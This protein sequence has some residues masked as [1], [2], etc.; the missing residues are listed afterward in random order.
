MHTSRDFDSSR[1]CDYFQYI[2][3]DFNGDTTGQLAFD[4]QSK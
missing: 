2:F 3:Q 1:C 4:N